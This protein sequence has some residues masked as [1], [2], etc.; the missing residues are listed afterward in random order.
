M[1][2]KERNYSTRYIKRGLIVESE[3]LRS[4][5]AKLSTTSLEEKSV[6]S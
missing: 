4:R 6:E 2:E 1:E 3:A 5:S